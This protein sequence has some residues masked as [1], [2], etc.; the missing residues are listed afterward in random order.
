[1]T[2][3][4]LLAAAGF[5]GLVLIPIGMPGLWVF[6]AS[7]VGYRLLVGPRLSWAVVGTVGL[8]ALAA[9][10]LDWTVSAH[11]TK[12]FG[13]SSRA[14][15][16]ALAGGLAGAIVG[17]PVPVIGSVIGSFAGAFLGALLAE[18]SQG[19]AHG[20]AGKAAWGA[21]LGRMAATVV[22]IGFGFVSVVLAL[23]AAWPLT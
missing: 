16:W 11:Y 7:T 3:F 18:Y 6:F 2:A 1:M 4:Y 20:D 17:V 23:Y 21:I 8:L 13:G 5:L 14:G 9:E 15:W 22:K 19:R 10:V 12:K